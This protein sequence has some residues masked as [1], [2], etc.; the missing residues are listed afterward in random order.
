MPR[1]SSRE[2]ILDAAE[3]VVLEGGA[4]H[5][6]LDAVAKK[7]GVS[8]GGLIY[9]FPTKEALLQAMIVR[10]VERLAAARS[11][12][13]VK[14][15][16]GPTREIRAYVLSCL[17]RSHKDRRIGAALLAAVAHDPK[18]LAPARAIYKKTLDEIVASGLRR[19]RVAVISLATDGLWLMELLGVCP[20]SARQREEVIAELLRMAE[21]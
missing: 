13:R 5:M 9:N 16:D 3:E 8:K 21:G 6:T 10:Y 17:K 14:L 20:F 15:T 4:G 1:K 7:A 12:Q 11:K 18:L 2:T 19:E